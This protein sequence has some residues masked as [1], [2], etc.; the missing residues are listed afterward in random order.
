MES[1]SNPNVSLKD[2]WPIMKEVIESGGEFT[3]YPHGTSML[4][5]IRQGEDQVVLVEPKDI[6]VG[7]IVFYRRNDGHFVLH[8]LVKITKGQYVM[9]GDNQYLLEYGITDKHP[10]HCGQKFDAI[11][12][13]RDC[14]DIADE[15]HPRE[16][17]YRRAKAVYL[18]LLFLKTLAAHMQFFN[19]LPLSKSAD[20][21]T[22]RAANPVAKRSYNNRRPRLNAS[23]Q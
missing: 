8:R 2:F 16:Q 22:C 10:Y 13:E 6:K 3:F 18:R 4:P 12:S 23:R 15:W 19:P 21:I 7:D 17:S 20:S 11:K 14:K 9:C 1:L 5:L